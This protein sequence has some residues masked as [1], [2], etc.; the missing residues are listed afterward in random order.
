MKIP[1][2]EYI[3]SEVGITYHSHGF[4]VR[5]SMRALEWNDPEF[6]VVKERPNTL[7]MAL[8]FLIGELVWEYGA[9]TETLAEAVKDWDDQPYEEDPD[10]G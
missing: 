4:D 8:Y 3:D 9:D 6:A 2:R 1:P 7:L 5:I 10:N